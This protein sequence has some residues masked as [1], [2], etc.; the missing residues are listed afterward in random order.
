[1]NES[2]VLDRFEFPYDIAVPELKGFGTRDLEDITDQ[3]EDVDNQ[4]NKK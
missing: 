1:M 4:K 2:C 3:G